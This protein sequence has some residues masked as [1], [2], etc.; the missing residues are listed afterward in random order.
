M[1]TSPQDVGLKGLAAML[2]LLSIC[3]CRTR[4]KPEESIACRQ[5]STQVKDLPWLWKP[6]QTS[7]EVKN[8]D[9][10]GPTKR[11]YVLQNFTKRK[12]K[13][14]LR[15]VW[16]DLK[17]LFAPYDSITVTIILTGG[18]FDLLNGKLWYAEWVA[19]PFARQRSVCYVDGNVDAHLLGGKTW[20][21]NCLYLMA[22]LQKRNRS[23]NNR[24]IWKKNFAFSFAFTG[25]ERASTSLCVRHQWRI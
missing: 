16:A 13:H 17:I 4:G 10:S 19:Y 14:L 11:T 24:Q 22:Y 25:C 9:I 20:L 8:R 23:K 5:E 1:R 21:L 6:G 15:F 2:T 12:K 18:T 7:P 3:R